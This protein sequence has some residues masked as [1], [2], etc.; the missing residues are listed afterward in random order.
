MTRIFLNRNI[1]AGMRANKRRAKRRV[2]KH[3]PM[4]SSMRQTT[5]KACAKHAKR[6]KN[7][8]NVSF[9]ET[10]SVLLISDKDSSYLSCGKH[11]PPNVG[12][13]RVQCGLCAAT[14]PLKNEH[15]IQ[16]GNLKVLYL[17]INHIII[18]YYMIYLL[19]NFFYEFFS[20]H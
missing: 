13:R 20:F 18:N 7:K 12:T 8:K 5:L 1:N 6:N 14:K 9:F 11:V 4:L 16:N 2:K 15:L 10:D 19:F 3:I 17:V